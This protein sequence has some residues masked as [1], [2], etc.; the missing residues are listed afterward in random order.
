MANDINTVKDA[1]TLIARLAA[2]MFA[3]KLQFCRTIDQEDASI[4]AGHNGYNAGDQ[5]KVS[6]PARFTVRTG[7]ALS[8]QDIEEDYATLTLDD[9][10]GIDVALTSKEIATDLAIKSWAKRVLDPMVSRLAQDVEAGYLESA[11]NATANAVGTPGSTTYDTDTVLSVKQKINE[12]ACP[13]FDNRSILLNPYAERSAVNA[14]KGLFQDSARVAEQYVSGQM[15]RADGFEFLAS[16]LLPLHTNGTDVTFE[17]STTVSTEGQVTLVVEGLTANT[18]T[19]TKGTVF[20]IDT[21]N[22][23]DPITKADL[24]YAKQF[25]VAADATANGSGVATLTLTEG[26]T[27]TGGKQNVTAFPA[28]GDTCTPLGSASTGYRQSLAYHKSAFRMVSVPLVKPDGVDMVGQE[29]EDGITMR[30]IRQY[31]ISDD[32]LYMRLDYLGGFVATRPEW[33]CRVYN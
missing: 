15:G 31:D 11:I 32:K 24:G 23:V 10:K 14:R 3:N 16:N 6:K 33:A 13:D 19:V 22:A 7:A 30:V 1:G 21:V 9:Q 4:F 29:T 17:V 20:T 2:K 18:G 27:T 5:I 25:V 8:A 28:D 26:F 12:N